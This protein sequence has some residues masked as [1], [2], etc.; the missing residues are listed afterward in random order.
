MSIPDY[1]FTETE[2]NTIKTN[3]TNYNTALQNY[4]VYAQEC[5][6]DIALNIAQG[7]VDAITDE[8]LFN[9][10]TNEGIKQGLFIK[11]GLLFINGQYIQAYNFK[12]VR[13]SDGATTFLIDSNGNVEITPSKLTITT[14]TNTN[15]ATKED[16]DTSIKENLGYNIVLDNDN[17]TIPTDKNLYPLENNSYVVNV[18]AYKGATEVNAT[19][20]TV[21]TPTGITSTVSGQTITFS[22]SKTTS[23]ASTSGVIT[24]PIT[25]GTALFNKSFSWSLSVQSVG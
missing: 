19:I 18:K 6:T 5:N 8:E 9:K 25:V 7:V 16:V 1:L 22:V 15:I 4:N 24:I 17:Q 3:I 11:D 10:V 14:S 2:I 23:F 13:K 12:A 21:R 20:G